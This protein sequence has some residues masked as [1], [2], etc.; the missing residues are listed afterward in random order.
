M[1]VEPWPVSGV[2]S[3]VEVGANVVDGAVVVDEHTSVV[4]VVVPGGRVVVEPCPVSGVVSVVDVGAN[5]VDG[6][7][8]DDGAEVELEAGGVAVVDVGANVVDVGVDVLGGNVLEDGEDVVELQLVSR[9]TEVLWVS[10]KLSGHAACTVNV[11]VPV[12]GPGTSVT[13]VVVPLSGTGFAYPVTANVCAPMVATAESMLMVSVV[14]LLPIVQ[15]T[16]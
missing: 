5:V 1:V 13:A 10:V 8:V 15:F 9:S 3:V 12:V 6:A 11:T 7:V 16:T 14:S 4:V 2:V